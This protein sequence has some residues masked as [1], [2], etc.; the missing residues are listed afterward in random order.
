ML[1]ANAKSATNKLDPKW[2]TLAFFIVAN[3]TLVIGLRYCAVYSDPDKPFI[4]STLVLF[5]EL[6]KLA[7]SALV[8][9]YFDAN[10]NLKSFLEILGRGYSEEGADVLQLIVPA[11]LYTVQNNLQYIIESSQSFQVLYQLKLLTTALFYSALLSRRVS[12][13]EWLSILALAIG[14]GIVQS[15]QSEFHLHHVSNLVGIE[16]VV[17]ACIT[18]GFAGV[19]FEKIVKESRSSVWVLNIQLSFLCCGISAVSHFMYIY[20]SHILY[21]LVSVALDLRP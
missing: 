9:Y 19:Y 2:I 18:S 7:L 5:T 1:A 16:A 20:I 15:S 3:T 6:T 8:C 14:V 13:R 12:Y 10:A 4:S 21:G 11:L 17:V